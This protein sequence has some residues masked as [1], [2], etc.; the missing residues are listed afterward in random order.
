[1]VADD[2][3]ER[4]SVA[5]DAGDQLAAAR[6]A[7]EARGQVQQMR[8]KTDAQVRDGADG[9]P[10]KKINVQV[11]KQTAQ[12]NYRRNRC[13]KHDRGGRMRPDAASQGLLRGLRPVL[14]KRG[15]PFEPLTQVER[16]RARKNKAV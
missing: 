16:I 15:R 14:H 7:E 5:H 3:L 1:G 8:E 13:D 4:V 11:G 9:G 6:A 10:L 12:K 2:A